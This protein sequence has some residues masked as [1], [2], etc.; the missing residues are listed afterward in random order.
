NVT[1]F[2]WSPLLAVYTGEDLTN[3]TPVAS[4]AAT[5]LSFDAA[6]GTRY[7]IALDSDTTSGGDY[8][9]SVAFTPAPPNDNFDQRLV[10]PSS[11]TNFT[12]SN[13]AAT[14]E[15]GEPNH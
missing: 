12:G 3:L 13:L 14:K 11:I 10:L 5:S 6:F 4:A 8:I 15:A 7:L 9:L 1:V 2:N